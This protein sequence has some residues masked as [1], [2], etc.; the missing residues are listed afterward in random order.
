MNLTPASFPA[1]I[2]IVDDTPAN[3]RLITE[4]L[5][6]R[7]FKTRPVLSGKLAL[8]AAR[9]SPP[10]LVLLDINMPELDG[11]EVCQ[12]LKTDPRM[13]EVPVVF[14]SARDE[15]IDK[16]RAFRAGAVD[17]ISKPFHIEEV[18][19][20]VNVH[21]KLKALR[22]ESEERSRQV[23]A[24]LR[25]LQA[26]QAKL[27]AELSRAAEYVLSLLPARLEK[28]QVR[29][30]WRMIPSTQLGGDA[31]GYHWLDQENFVFYLLDVS[32]HGVGPALHSVSILNT[33][34]NRNLS[35]IDF[36]DPGEV[37]TALNEVYSMRRYAS[38][39]FTIGYG[40]LHL[41][42]GALRYAGG[43]HPATIVR[44]PTGA[45]VK[46]DSGGPPIGCFEGTRYAST[47]LAGVAP[48]ELCVFSDGVYDVRRPGGSRW[49]FNGFVEYLASGAAGDP[50]DLDA[51][52]RHVIGVSGGGPLADDFSIL[53]VSVG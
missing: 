25:A 11:Y 6:E 48:A 7:G 42:D 2:L 24:A 47:V 45:R 13:R 22:Q 29:T 35:G 3:L 38:F 19:A 44:M 40:V 31:L 49:S 51:V 9:S 18:E 33:L 36:S 43:G 8:Q 10:D 16:V 4:M 41:P 21:L 15:T 5:R 37:L 32:G 30:D 12:Q 34:R 14:L 50:P 26:A 39:Y 20:R 1:D 27:R 17:Y 52:H 23:E 53:R 46:L 28:G